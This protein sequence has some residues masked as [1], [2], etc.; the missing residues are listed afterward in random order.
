MMILASTI[1]LQVLIEYRMF[2]PATLNI[3]VTSV[4]VKEILYQSVI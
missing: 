3:G 1:A 2:V 4:E